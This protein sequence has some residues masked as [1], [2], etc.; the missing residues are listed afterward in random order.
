[1]KKYYKMLLLL[2]FALACLSTLFAQMDEYDEQMT[3]EQLREEIRIQKHEIRAAAKEFLVD[4][5]PTIIKMDPQRADQELQKFTNVL[6]YLGDNEVLYLLGHMY[7]R[8]GENDRAITIFDSLLRTDLNQ[9]ARKMLNLVVYRKLIGFL[10]AGDR[11]TAK[12]FLSHIVFEN[13]NTEQYFPCYLYL[14]ADISADS[15]N[16][17]EI[18]NLVENYNHNRDIVLNVLLPLKQR[19]LSRINNLDLATYFEAPTQTEYNHLSTQIDQIQ[20][21][22][23][24]IYNEM[25]GM[26]GMLFADA[27]VEAHNDEMIKLDEIKRLLADYANTSTLT[28][29]RLQPALKNITSVKQN[30]DFYDRLLKQFDNLLQQN[31]LS[32]SARDPQNADVYVG[33]LYL[34]R[35]IQTKRTISSYDEIIDEIDDLLASGE[36]PEYTERLNSE[37]QWAVTKKSEAEVLHQKYLADVQSLESDESQYFSQVLAEYDALVEDKALLEDTANELEDY[38]LTEAREIINSDLRGEIRPRIAVEISDVAYSAD[39]DQVFTRGYS[40][41]LTSIEYITLKMAYR[42]L[43]KGYSSFLDNQVNL[44]SEE[45]QTQREHWRQ[46]QLDLINEISS[47]IESNPDFTSIEQPGG[48]PL[49]S[50]ADLYYSLAELQYYAIPQDL[51]PALNSYRMALQ[52]D[53]NLPDRDLALYNIAFITSEIKR[54]EVSNNKIAYRNTARGNENP[55]ANA[56]Y[57]QSN[58]SEAHDAL[59]EIVNDHPDSKMWEEAVYRLGL[60]NF[61]YSTDSDDPVPFRDTAIEYFNQIVDN[62]QSPLY[63]DALYQRGWVRLNSL[64]IEDLRLA[65]NDFME[66]L[67]ATDAGLI[68][69][70]QIASD[71]RSDAVENIAYCLIAMDGTDYRSQSRGVAEL[72]RVFEG[73]SNQQIIEQVVNRSTEL[74]LDM[75]V[76]LQAVDF[77]EFKISAAPLALENPVLLDSILVLYHNSNQ[78]MR[79]GDNLDE[80][81]QNIYQRIINN[82]NHESQWFDVNKNEDITE[83][84]EIIDNAYTQRGYRLYNT[85]A[86]NINRESLLAYETHMESYDSFANLHKENYQAFKTETDSLIVTAY[87][88]LADRTGSIPD[89]LEA[90]QRLYAYN[91]AYPNNSQFYENEKLAMDYSRTAFDRTRTAFEDEEYI[92]PAGSPTDLDEAF[93]LLQN[94]S[95]RFLYVSNQERFTTPARLSEAVDI[96]LLLGDVQFGR[97]KY[98]EAV[99]LYN[100][101][102]ENSDIMS[103]A[104][105]RET[106]LKLAEISIRQEQ[107]ADAENWFRQALPLALNEEDKASIN[108]DILVQIQN[109]FESASGSGDY[110]TE[111]NER[112]RLAAEMDPSRGLEILGQKNEAVEAF[113]KAGAYQ[114]A[115]DLLMELAANDADIDAAYARYSQ[116]IEIAE[117]DSMMNNPDLAKNLEQEFITKYPASNYSFFLRLASI[118]HL[119]ENDST[120]VQAAEGY[121]ALFEEVQTGNIDNGEV[122]A[123]SLLAD[124]IR[125]YNLQGDVNTGYALMNRFI[126]TYPDHSDT[127]P[128]MEYMAKGYYDRNET[129]EYNRIARDIYLK[130]STKSS[131]YQNVALTEL[132]SIANEFDTAYLNGD[133]EGALAARDRYL[134][135]ESAYKKEGLSFDEEIYTV[136]NNVQREYD[137]IQKRIAFLES[138]DSRL[139][140]LER[141]AIFTQ[142]PAQQIR[143]NSLTKWDVNLGGGDRRIPKYKDTI[144]AEVSKVRN[145]MRE[146]AE[147]GYAIDNERQIDAYTLISKIYNRGAE[148][149]GT[150]IRT[151]FQITEQGQYYASQWGTDAE[152]QLNGFVAQETQDYIINSLIWNNQIYT[153]YH[154]AGY[155]SDATHAAK[156]ALEE[157]N[158]S[159]D[160]RSMDLTLDNNWQQSLEPGGSDLSISQIQSPKGQALGNTMIPANTTLRIEREFNLDLEP[161]F[162]YLHVVFPLDMEVKLNG[163]LVNSSWVAVDSLD[164]SKPITTRYSYL[165]PGELF[166]QGNNVIEVS[167]GNTSSNAMQAALALQMMTSLQRIRENIPPEQKN[168]FTNQG[169]RVINVDP[170]TGEESSDYASEASEWNI[171]WENLADMEQSAARPIWVSELDG[172]VNN[173]ILETEFIM[174]SE[175]KQGKIE[176]IAPETVSVFLNGSEIGNAI[177]D[178]DPDPLTIYKGEILIPAQNVVTGRNILRFEISNSSIY[179]GFLAKISYAQAGKEEIR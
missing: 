51:N 21:D 69:D 10:Q 164:A 13:Y 174:D 105:K 102:L 138:Y 127:V 112:L 147:S 150:Q 141:S 7:A 173:L 92:A 5:L 131:Y 44:S 15:G 89:F 11:E 172:P 23:T 63:Y 95:E 163:S 115:I 58:F 168:L 156:A 74:K 14:Y 178:Y 37:R 162:A 124:A 93:S 26:E 43:L 142:T 123:S 91:D 32:L 66:I 53:P 107:Y 2:V 8:V 103:N 144:E 41:V 98:P 57:S 84:I 56:L 99:Q 47:F 132:G 158:Q 34:D 33:D 129:E 86:S 64:D 52:L 96:I 42:D 114:Q 78:T 110:I 177:F 80:I 38:V 54:L 1:M 16:Y 140:A 29:E 104:D 145:L 169:W 117:A 49:V 36:Y 85:F 60:L 154:L 20:F 25:I 176:F 88:V 59:T 116:A 40:Q 82:Y 143:V 48:A 3:V 39:R 137:D 101:A 73:Y 22:L 165:I 90:I 9:G 157:Y 77:L 152:N 108:Q 67:L 109:S 87:T 70:P 170:E 28:E 179:R 148:V 155:Q 31:F 125:L 120:R 4:E 136:F 121:L 46:E 45:V 134:S 161:N 113:K 118:N 167:M 135:V 128:Y 71:Y 149:V 79:E 30:L 100:Q 153:Q 75:G 159:I 19:V 68:S 62:R 106:Y 111:A 6:S 50:A 72:Q 97:Q 151:F 175:F 160:Y 17:D 126:A 94:S 27:I 133:Y 55:P 12:D 61:S 35:V 83:Q 24:A 81:T 146:A 65:M 122:A 130:D 171:T 119:A 139:N 166:T 76:S 18:I